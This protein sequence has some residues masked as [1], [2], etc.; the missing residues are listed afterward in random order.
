[1]RYSQPEKMQIIRLLEESELP[2]TPTLEELDVPKSTFYRWYQRYQE[3]GYDGLADQKPTPRQFWNRIPEFVRDHVVEVA[4][5]QPEKSP[6]QLAWHITDN[7]EYYI[8]ESSVYRILKDFDLVTSPAFQMISASDRFKKPTKRVNE[9]WQT[10]FTQFKVISWGWYYLC[11]VLDDCTRYI[12]SW[13]LSKTM[14]ASDVEETLQ[15]ALDKTDITQVKVKHRP[16]LLSDNGPCFVSQALTNYL[17]RYRLTHIRSA[18]Y[19]PMTQGKI[20]RYHRSMKNIVKLDTFYFPWELEQTIANFV[21][22]YN[23]ERYHESLGN[24]TPADVYFGRA[25]EVKDKR[26]EIKKKTLKQRRQLNRQM[27]PNT[28]S[29]EWQILS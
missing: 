18:P 17:K 20:E 2:I 7:E 19:H 25:E 29:F 6:R 21:E 26:E 13:R 28:L 22:Y 16:R 1:M 14:A 5:E 8:S 24:L 11:T 23:H 3:A 4:L 15:V 27:A 10:D 9:M 12:L